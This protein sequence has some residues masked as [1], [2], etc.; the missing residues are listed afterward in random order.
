EQEHE[1]HH[2]AQANCNEPALRADPTHGRPYWTIRTTTSPKIPAIWRRTGVQGWYTRP[3]LRRS[4][5][6][7]AGRGGR[8]GRSADWSS[9]WSCAGNA[10]RPRSPGPGTPYRW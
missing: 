4:I 8:R 10:T 5:S 9:S 6:W 3:E 7:A 1:G 2:E